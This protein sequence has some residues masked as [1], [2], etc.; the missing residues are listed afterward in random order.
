MLGYVHAQHHPIVLPHR[1]SRYD[2]RHHLRAARSLK[3]PRGA[4]DGG[5]IGP[6]HPH[7]GDR[8]PPRRA[9]PGRRG[10]RGLRNAR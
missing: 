9:L 1:P 4:A 7:G 8:H 3:G 5:S 2:G 6:A 10:R